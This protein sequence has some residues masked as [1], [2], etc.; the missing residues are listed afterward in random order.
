MTILK[1]ELDSLDGLDKAYHPLYTQRD[2]KHVLTGVDGYTPENR[3]SVRRALEA[4]RNNASKHANELKAWKTPF[5]DRKPEDIQA[6]LDKIEEYKLAARG[7][8]D[9]KDLE[10]RVTARLSS[11]TKPLERKLN[12]ATEKAAKA[13]ARVKAYEHAEER[14]AIRAA[15]QREALASGALPESYADGGGLL[16]VLEGQLKVEVEVTT[17]ES[18]NPVRKLG[19][20]VSRDGST[21]LPKLLQQVQSTQ[22]YF[23]GTSKGGGAGARGGGNGGG[24]PVAKGNPW[25]QETFNR[26][27]QLR[28][29][30]ENPQLAARYK[31]EAGVS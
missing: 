6:E 22:G 25:K 15:I 11:A 31:S 27:E 23:W 19:K 3:E 21:E 14:S 12:E 16:A 18:G 2:G 28:L 29:K 26:T 17:D 13:E 30:R 8:L 5:G 10:E 7:K 9:E 4:E 20:V 1:P 24:G